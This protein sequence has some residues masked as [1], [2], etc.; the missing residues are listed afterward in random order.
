MGKYSK[1]KGVKR[2]Q[3]CSSGSKGW[4]CT[5]NKQLSYFHTEREAAKNFD[6]CLIR[7]NKEPVNILRRK[8]IE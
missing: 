7:D 1:Y 8:T 2:Q 3:R 6:L 5:Y 4:V